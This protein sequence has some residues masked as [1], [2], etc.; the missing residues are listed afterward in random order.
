[1]VNGNAAAAATAAILRPCPLPRIPIA[2]SA[3][4]TE[5]K[6]RREK[7]WG[8][9]TRGPPVREALSL[10]PTHTRILV[11]SVYI[12]TNAHGVYACMLGW[13]D[14]S[15]WGKRRRG[16][17]T[18]TTMLQLT[19]IIAPGAALLGSSSDRG[20]SSITTLHRLRRHSS[21]YKE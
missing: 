1:M 19:V 18:T 3:I 8:C 4:E 21:T 14:V 16:V 15:S 2:E 20:R 13:M 5:R 17:A 10:A 9:Y 7:G 6:R 12:C 11:P